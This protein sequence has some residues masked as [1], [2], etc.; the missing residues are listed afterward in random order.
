MANVLFSHDSQPI[1]LTNP[2]PTSQG[3]SGFINS[4]ITTL[5]SGLSTQ[6]NIPGNGS[7]K[8]ILTNIGHNGTGDI[9]QS[10]AIIGASGILTYQM[11][12]AQSGYPLNSGSSLS[13]DVFSPVICGISASGGVRILATSIQ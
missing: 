2:L 9:I 7:R 5:V 1:G 13:I 8:V 12:Q 4:A 3:G 10:R 6:I 11:F